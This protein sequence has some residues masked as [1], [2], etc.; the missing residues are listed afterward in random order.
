[1]SGTP[2]LAYALGFSVALNLALFAVARKAWKAD[3][4][5]RR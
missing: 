2:W 1:M 5:W 3:R 4:R